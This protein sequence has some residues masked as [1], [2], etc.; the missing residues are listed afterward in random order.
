MKQD[1]KLSN[2]LRALPTPDLMAIQSR[3]R[4]VEKARS[5]QIPVNNTKYLNW[6]LLA[7]RGFGKTR[8]AA[9]EVWWDC[10]KNPGIIYGVVAPTSDTVRSLCFEGVS[11]LLSVI[12]KEI[13]KDAT[14]KPLKI[15][16]HN[17]SVMYGYSSEKYERLRGPN[18]H[19]VWLDELAAW[20]YLE[21]AYSMIEFALRLGNYP[22]K[23]ITT[24]PKPL[25]LIKK[26]IKEEHTL[27]TTGN[28]YEN[29]ANLASQFIET[30]LEKY[31]GT[32]LGRQELHAEILQDVEGALWSFSMLEECTDLEI[33]K[34]FYTS[35]TN[36]YEFERI[37]VAI[38]PAI[39]AKKDS[40]ETGI[41]VAAKNNKKFYVLD[42]ASGKYS[43]DE[44]ARIAVNLFHKWN[45][46]YIIGEKN[47][48]GD[49]IKT[50]IKNI[51]NNVPIRLVTATK[52][53][54]LRAEP[55]AALYEQ[56]KVI[57]TKPF[58]KLND[59]MTSFTAESKELK[60]RLDALVWNLTYLS[61]GIKRIGI[62]S[63]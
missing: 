57:H 61:K 51:D 6:L 55:I 18:F 56:N 34:S 30:I 36:N 32:R 43:P 24:T 46:D 15:I 49:M 13:I 38:D 11:G 48:G 7:G 58:E 29:K 1:Q 27:V 50:I 14:F 37:G 47:Q 17:D 26:L 52:G 63:V 4:W 5:K 22:R 39:T 16:L 8:C 60:D 9:E 35:S 25:K 44:W 23:I 53:K 62:T 10:Y 3:M 19:R 59:Q 12:P 2:M 20:E 28:T 45:A 33:L 40:A 54:Y 21:E 31:E 41:N 42:D